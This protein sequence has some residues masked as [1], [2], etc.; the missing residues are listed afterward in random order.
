M[1]RVNFSRDFW[2]PYAELSSSVFHVFI[3]AFLDLQEHFRE[4][5]F[6]TLAT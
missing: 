1:S 2:L 3:R 4:F 6:V 5:F